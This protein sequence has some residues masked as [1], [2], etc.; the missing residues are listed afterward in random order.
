MASFL[1]SVRVTSWSI[2]CAGEGCKMD[3]SRNAMRGGWCF[4][5]NNLNHDGS[6]FQFP[7]VGLYSA[8]RLRGKN[9][10]TKLRNGVHNALDPQS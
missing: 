5:A 6:V 2:R 1:N 9:P 8:R 10:I 4:S 7:A 3:S